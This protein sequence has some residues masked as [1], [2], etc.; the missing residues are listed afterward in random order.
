MRRAKGI[1]GEFPWNLDAQI[2]RRPYESLG[3]AS[4]IGLG[5]GILLGSRI[6]RAVLAGAVSLAFVELSR[7]YA[8]RGDTQAEG[9][10]PGGAAADAS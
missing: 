3:V 8:R 10:K 4:A 7:A 2:K 5:T 9:S 6:L 1:I